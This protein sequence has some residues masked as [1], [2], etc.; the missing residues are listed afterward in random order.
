MNDSII[1]I[2]AGLALALI[3]LLIIT[4]SKWR[5]LSKTKKLKG[6][7]AWSVTGDYCP[8]VGINS[9]VRELWTSVLIAQHK[10]GIPEEYRINEKED[11]EI[12][13][14]I[15]KEYQVD[16]ARKYF[17]SELALIKSKYAVSGEDY[18]MA[19]FYEFLTKR[20]C[21][22]EVIGHAMHKERLEQKHYG[23][24]GGACYDATYL[25]SDF[26]LIYHKLLYITFRY[27][28]ASRIFNPENLPDWQ[29]QRETGL[30]K[31]LETKQLEVSCF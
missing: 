22:N 24:W 15:I 14:E 29:K 10:L 30:K 21:Y 23:D 26:G 31:V 5:E 11:F 16:A 3:V 25:L 4:V 8:A 7:V 27:L 17:L 20:Q 18:F 12:C 19:A 28:K 6:L 13:H 9:Y 1:E 2:S